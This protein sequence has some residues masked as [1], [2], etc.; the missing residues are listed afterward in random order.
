MDILAIRIWPEK[1]KN[2]EFL[3]LW[4]QVIWR[5]PWHW[6]V[7]LL[8]TFW[9]IFMHGWS[10]VWTL[11]SSNGLI[12]ALC[13]SPHPDFS[14]NF[15]FIQMSIGLLLNINI[16]HRTSEVCKQHAI[17]RLKLHYCVVYPKEMLSLNVWVYNLCVPEDPD[18]A[19]VAW[20]AFYMWYTCARVSCNRIL[21]HG[22][23]DIKF[24]QCAKNI[25]NV[26]WVVYMNL[27]CKTFDHV[28]LFICIQNLKVTVC[29]VWTVGEIFKKYFYMFTRDVYTTEV[30]K[31]RLTMHKYCEFMS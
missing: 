27:I 11:E 18:L 6:P 8:G 20:N 3:S 7:G 1:S 21:C 23:P 29:M 31:S 30:H 5:W 26:Y 10:H 28:G 22:Y 12:V 15:N 2:H 19:Q 14:N 25:L 24:Y 17:S 4:G 16:L 9:H 13:F